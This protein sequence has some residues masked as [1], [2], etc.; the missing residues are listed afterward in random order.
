MLIRW[1]VQR[2]TSVLPKSVNPA[3]IRANLEAA[4]LELPA[5]DFGALS[6]LPKQVGP[7][8]DGLRRAPGRA[9]LRRVLRRVPHRALWGRRGAVRCA[10]WA[11]RSKLLS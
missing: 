4:A 5:A 6:S 1:A 7:C 11:R 2:G 9:L 10:G 3:R 8:G